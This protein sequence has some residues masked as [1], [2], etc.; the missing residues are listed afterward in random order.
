MEHEQSQRQ[1]PTRDGSR[2]RLQTKPLRTRNAIVAQPARRD[3][4]A[5][6]RSSGLAD[7]GKLDARSR[8]AAQSVWKRALGLAAL[9]CVL[10]S[11]QVFAGV[12]MQGFYLDCPG[13]WYPTMQ[14]NA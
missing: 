12:M 14:A 8:F 4:P 7:W 6:S 13:P 11:A 10:V 3:K 5:V 2:E 9:T 1:F